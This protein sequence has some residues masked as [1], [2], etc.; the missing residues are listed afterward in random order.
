MTHPAASGVLAEAGPVRAED[1]FDVGAVHD[2]LCGALGEPPSG[3]PAVR[4]F[5]SG[6]SNLTYLLRYPDRELVLRRPPMGHRAASAHDMRREF[7][8]QQA[9]RP[10]YPYVPRVL[11]LCDDPAVIGTDFYVMERVPGTILGRRLPAGFPSDPRFLR[12]LA[13]SV[14]DRLAEL[15]A[16][17][18]ASAGL[19][20]LGKGAGYVGRQVD[21]W[22]RRYRAARTPRSPTLEYVMRW[23]DERQP[24]DVA[25][26]VIHNDYRFDNV[27]L[28]PADPLT[29]R[30]VLDWE[31][32]TLGDPLMDLGS[33]LAYWV[34]ADDDKVFASSAKQPTYLPGMPTRR[35][36]VERHT[37]ALGLAPVDWTF[38]EVFGLFRL[39]VIVQQI[40][41]RYH[42]G[43]TTNPAFQRY[44]SRVAYL[45]HR[46][47]RIA[48]KAG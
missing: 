33:A 17:D 1:A 18:P 40:Y 39:A 44:W 9:L 6:A 23:L 12:L 2:W 14:L 13:T 22:A 28:D 41:L 10:V 32:A 11:A 20:G 7:R 4:Q 30:G 29:V 35:E 25:T 46:C 21:G 36:I 15:H 16:I 47:Q 5:S 26:R 48:R 8:V 19:T 42:R 31:M 24:A 38:Y 37:A 45:G 27:V 3:P 34:E 43:E